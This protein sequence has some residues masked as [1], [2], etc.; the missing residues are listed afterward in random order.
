MKL[1]KTKDKENNLKAVKKNDDSHD[2]WFLTR[3][4]RPKWS[5]TTFSKVQ[6]GKKKSVCLKFYIQLKYYLEIKLKKNI[7]RWS[8]TKKIYCHQTYSENNLL[9]QVLQTKEKY[10]K[11][12]WHIMSKGWVKEMVNFWV[13]TIIDYSLLSSLKYCIWWLKAKIIT[14]IITNGIFHE[15][16]CNIYDN[17]KTRRI[18]VRFLRSILSGKIFTENFEI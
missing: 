3:N 7:V 17:Y 2:C 5:G 18:K 4:H 12:T 16:R 8:K 10:L 15:Y 14:K 9:K 13:N 1:L 11:E 6:R